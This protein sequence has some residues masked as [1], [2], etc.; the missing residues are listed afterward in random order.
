[1]KLKRATLASGLF[2]GLLIVLPTVDN[3]RNLLLMPTTEMLSLLQRLSAN[4][5][6]AGLSGS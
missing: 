4:R 6:A 3:L 1:M 2:L 5:T